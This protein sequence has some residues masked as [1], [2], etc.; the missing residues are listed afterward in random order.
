MG[1]N[2]NNHKTGLL[3]FNL[4][5]DIQVKNWF[6]FQCLKCDRFENDNIKAT[7]RES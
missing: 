1:N 4:D 5:R 7:Y 3:L 6:L 2:N